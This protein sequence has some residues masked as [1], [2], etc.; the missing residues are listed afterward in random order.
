[1]QSSY[2]LLMVYH[3]TWVAGQQDQLAAQLLQSCE[4][5]L[6]DILAAL[7]NY[8]VAFEALG[9]MRGM[10]CAFSFFLSFFF[11]LVFWLF[12]LT[13][14]EDQIQAALDCLSLPDE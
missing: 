5:G 10:F 2:A 9:G 11:L 13:R 14:G 12:L 7:A 1:M 8:S 3:R 4:S 6:R